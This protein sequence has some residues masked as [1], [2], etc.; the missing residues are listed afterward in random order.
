MELDGA[1]RSAGRGRVTAQI[2]ASSASAGRCGSTSGSTRVATSD[3][4]GPTR[5]ATSDPTRVATSDSSGPTRVATSDSTRVAR[6]SAGAPHPGDRNNVESCAQNARASAATVLTGGLGA[7][8]APIVHAAGG[9]ASPHGRTSRA[10]AR[11]RRTGPLARE[12]EGAALR[13]ALSVT[14]RERPTISPSISPRSTQKLFLTANWRDPGAHD[15]HRRVADRGSRR[16]R[17]V[18]AELPPPG[19]RV[20]PRLN[21]RTQGKRRRASAG[22]LLA[23]KPSWGGRAR[24][25][26]RSGVSRVATLRS[27]RRRRPSSGSR[28]ARTALPAP[29]SSAPGYGSRRAGGASSP[30]R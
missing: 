24:R 2:I 26:L 13:H 9:E 4:S 16:R 17:P 12:Q 23:R 21:G 22:C 5:V 19:S 20:T 11:R 7:P 25:E 30:G 6:G 14:H 8:S 15:L 28:R 27:R 3:S 10:A 1:A 29:A 18:R